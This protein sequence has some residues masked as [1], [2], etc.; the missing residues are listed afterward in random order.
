MRWLNN[1]ILSILLAMSVLTG[2][3][4]AASVVTPID[5]YYERQPY[6]G[7]GTQ[8]TEA[9]RAASRNLFPAASATY[10][11]YYGYH[12]AVDV[13]YS[14]PSEAQTTI[15]VRAIADG[16]VIS[17]GNVSGYGGLIVLRHEQPEAVTS[18]YGH[19]A[20]IRVKVGDAVTAG[21][22]IADLGTPYSAATSGERKHLHFGIH[23][24]AVLELNGYEQSAQ[25]LQ[26]GWY[27]PNVWLTARGAGPTPS[28]PSLSPTP[29]VVSDAPAPEKRGWLSRLW[30]ALTSWL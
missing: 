3:T 21:Q 14:D 11:K 28:Q 30:R 29:S 20:N 19:I 4:R 17:A 7:F 23:K 10:P 25:V 26:A 2:Q 6:V 27:D 15:P 16:T 22:V 8:V 9:F 13:E 12:A 5:G 1:L 18:L 24:G